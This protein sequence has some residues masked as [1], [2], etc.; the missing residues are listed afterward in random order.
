MI[1][2]IAGDIIGSLFEKRKKTRRNY[3][4]ELFSKKSHFTDDTILTVAQAE[5][6]LNGSDFTDKIHEYYSRYP[7]A[8]WGGFFRKWA[9]AKNRE[10]YNSFG[11]GSAMRV[12]PIGFAYNTYS[13]VLEKA[14]NS[15]EVSHNH[16]EGIKGAQA[17]AI[18]IYLARSGWPKRS[19]KDYLNM[20]FDYFLDCS[21]NDLERYYEFD[22]SCQGT[23]PA[24]LTVFLNSKS[25]EDAIR[26]AIIIGG[27]SDTIACIV[28]GVAQAYYGIPRFIRQKTLEYLDNDLKRVT[29]EF[30]KRYSI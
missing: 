21:M 28:G 16:P 10:P 24:A 29:L 19:I 20:K 5:C 22:S 12:S 25:F 18:A 23:M 1:G 27:D 15:A 7:R 30:C 17:T 8:G 9:E 13:E 4:F 11:N 14:S 26:K 6:I 2:A 3:N